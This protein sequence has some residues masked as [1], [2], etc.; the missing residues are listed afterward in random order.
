MKGGDVEN[1]AFQRKLFDLFLKAVYIY[2]D[3][4]M[5]LVFRFSVDGKDTDTILIF[6]DLIDDVESSAQCSYELRL[7]PPYQHNPSRIV[8]IG[9]GFG[10]V[11]FMRD[12]TA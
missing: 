2:D 10:F 8:P 5:K 3:D 7:G 12:L 1:K 6:D 9:G 11:V 4:T